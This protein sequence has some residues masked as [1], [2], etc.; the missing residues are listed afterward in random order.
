MLFNFFKVI[1]RDLL[2]DKTYTAISVLGLAAAISIS[3]VII[4]LDITFFTY[5]RFHENGDRI[6]QAFHKD[7]NKNNGSYYFT[8]TS[9]L[10]GE[11]LTN[12][13]PEIKNSVTVKDD[14]PLMFVSGDNPGVNGEQSGIYSTESLFSV[15]SFPVIQKLS[16]EVLKDNNSI[17][18]SKK[19]A[20]KYFGNVS[21]AMGKRIILRRAFERKEVYIS[22]VFGNVPDNSSL[23]FDYV[24]PLASLLKEQKW[25]SSLSNLSAS[26]FFDPGGYHKT[27]RLHN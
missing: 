6:Y 20:E 5:N 18:V 4:T 9:C 15:F 8:A 1:L 24:L 27:N 22:A 21:N 23:R 7:N 10:L 25:L 11:T 26:T 3:I 16:K 13:F 17:A 19:V 12:E 2:K 14:A